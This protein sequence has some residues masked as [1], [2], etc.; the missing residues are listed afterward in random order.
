MTNFNLP[1]NTPVIVGVGD[2]I[3]RRKVDGP[4]PLTLLSQSSELALYDTGVKN[5]IDY[6]DAIGVV[7]FSVDFSTA[8]NQSRF[9]YSNFPRSLAKKIGSKKELCELYSG[10]GGNA[11]QV[12]LE[13]ISKKIHN[14]EIHCALISGGEV[15]QTMI[16]KLK[17]GESLNWEDSPGGR[18]EIIGINDEGFSKEEKKHFMDLPSN[19]YPIFA[20][21]IRASKSQSSKEHLRECSELFSKF[22]K[23]A[24][25][26]PYAWFQK[27]RTP[28]EIENISDSNRLVGFPYT[29]Y[30]NSMIRVN[31]ASSLVLM[32]EKLCKKLKI[33]QNKKVYI[34]G[35]CVLNDIWNVSKR[36]A[37]DE[38]PAIRKCGKEALSQAGISL[39]EISFLDI[40]SC[41]PSAVQI[42]Q[43]ELS[44]D[45]NDK[46]PLTVTG[47]LPYFGGPG[48]AY[49]MFSTSEIV[50]KLRSNPNEYGMVTAN[51][52]FLTK[53][54]INILS[55]KPPME[56]DWGK[57][58]AGLQKEIDSK[59]IENLNSKPSGLGKVI[60]YTIVQ[61]RKNLEYGIV[62]GELED[63]SRF[64]AN[65]LG[66]ESF[67]KKMTEVEML[68]TKG[69]VKHTSER[70]IFKPLFI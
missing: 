37:L 10:M 7:R 6:L 27:F 61:G 55:C 45:S 39:S 32:S 1:D 14:N 38:S 29:K 8:T 59:E 48:N 4:D 51:S 64:V 68:E 33:P 42:A 5:I 25:L 41:F 18:P 20:N 17:S 13:E 36:P 35:S 16:S 65:V 15:L 50:K 57:N 47:G 67:L 31:M 11:P 62:I 23:V 19:V 58:C 12:L 46:R 21:A 60:S 26:N 49:T 53:H 56:I 40:Y 3:D 30:L 22:S 43:K 63:K 52:W 9:G 69:E 54:A 66:E 2:I 44:L 24:S 28:E 70:N 34:H